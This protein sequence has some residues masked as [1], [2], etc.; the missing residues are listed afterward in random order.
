MILKDFLKE[1]KITYEEFG[2]M[3][4][5]SKQ[6]VG[7]YVRGVCM[8]PKKTMLLIQKATNNRV[9]PLDFYNFSLTNEKD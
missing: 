9:Q 1:N 3:I 7:T 8:P 2:K 5:K 6:Q 4:N